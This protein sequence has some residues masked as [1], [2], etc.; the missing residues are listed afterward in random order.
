[1]LIK[2]KNQNLLAL[3]RNFPISQEIWRPITK[4]KREEVKSQGYMLGDFPV[5][6]SEYLEGKAEKFP[7]D[8]AE[9]VEL[10]KKVIKKELENCPEEGLLIYI[11]DLELMDFGDI[12][13]EII[14]KAWLDL[15]REYRGSIN[16][17]FITPDVY[18][19]KILKNEDIAKLPTL[20][21]N[22]I[23]WA[24]EIRLILRADGHYPPL[25]VRGIKE[26]DIQKTG[27]YQHPHI[28]W[29]NGKYYCG[30]FDRLIKNFH[31]SLYIP[32]SSTYLQDS[33]YDLPKENLET[34]AVFYL[35]IMKRAC[36][37]GWRP[38]EGRQKLPFLNG[39][40]L[41]QVLLEKLNKYP[42]SLVLKRFPEKIDL[43]N[44]VGLVETLKVFLDNRIAYLK[45]G[46]DLFT[47]EKGL[48]L[49][50]DYLQEIEEVTKW[51]DKAIK[52]CLGLYELYKATLPPQEEIKKT[53]ELMQSYSQ[54]VFMATDYLQRIWAKAPDT[55]YLVGKMYHY[56]YQQ[57]PPAMPAMIDKIDNMNLDQIEEYFNTLKSK[58]LA[59]TI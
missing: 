44:I 52:N 2:T 37:W 47:V 14:E 33:G 6:D 48:V 17:H 58:M 16:I 49:P 19:S 3:P 10:Y 36:N 11:Q 59:T 8:F 13:L 50:D 5:F 56:L 43:R 4:M 23:S 28:F 1:F 51:K 31:I 54:A 38:T 53:L 15:I 25:G 18:I 20:H 55:E 12:A 34:Q 45:Y 39:Y 21:F 40:K 9:G 29:E 27:L 30:I 24:P 26:Y 46:F 7:I 42:T 22:Q 32:V 57:Y 41:C 35:R